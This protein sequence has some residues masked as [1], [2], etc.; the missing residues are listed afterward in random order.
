MRSY[1]MIVYDIV[2]LIVYYG[3]YDEKI[4]LKIKGDMGGK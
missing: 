4:W 1:F 2:D 3:N